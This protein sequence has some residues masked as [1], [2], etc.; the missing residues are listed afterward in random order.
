M[1]GKPATKIS[2]SA[3]KY[4]NSRISDR[5]DRTL[6]IRKLAELVDYLLKSYWSNMNE[7]T[8]LCKY[9]EAILGIHNLLYIV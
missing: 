5:M 9:E 8:G 6:K 2:P 4:S 7:K 1:F 3:R